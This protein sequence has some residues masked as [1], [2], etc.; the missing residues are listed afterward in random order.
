M[1]AELFT[2]VP[3]ERLKAVLENLHAFTQLPIHLIGQ[4]GEQLMTFGES[5]RYCRL[6]QRNLFPERGCLAVCLQVG[7]QARDLGQPYI[8]SCHADLNHIAYPLLNRGELMG[9]IIVGPFLMDKPDSTLITNLTEKHKLTPMICLELYDELPGLQIIEPA[10]V[11]QLSCLLDHLL[12]PLMPA[13]RAI[14]QQAKEKLYQQS[15]INETIQQYKEQGVSES[16]EFFH[17]K[18]TALLSRVRTGNVQEAKALL[19]E[20]IGHVL[21]SQ[22]GNIENIHLM[23]VELTTL[24]SRVAI[25]GGAGTDKIYGLNSQYITRILLQQNQEDLCYLLQEVVESFMDAMFTHQDQG[26]PHIRKALRYIAA[27]YTQKLTLQHVAEEVGIS[28][29]HFST[30]FH[31]TVGVSFREYLSQIRVEGSKQLLLYTDYSL[32]DIAAAMGFPDQSNFSKVFKRITGISP[33]KYRG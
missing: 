14:L 29:N 1:T 32:A 21:F 28:P 20:L 18:E 31:K 8:F 24:L 9:C 3:R 30:L 22:G 26:N 16:R 6:L 25:D 19:N 23:A 13:E 2:R 33:G 7:Q 10:R 5:P 11:N 17:E 27:N 12:S 4:Q 15:R